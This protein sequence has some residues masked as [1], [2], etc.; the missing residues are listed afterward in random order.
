MRTLRNI[1]QYLADMPRGFSADGRAIGL[2]LD[3]ALRA[4]RSTGADVQPIRPARRPA[5]EVPQTRAS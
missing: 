5:A 2:G 4:Q 1:V 3:A